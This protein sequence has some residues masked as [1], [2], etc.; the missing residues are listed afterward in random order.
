MTRTTLAKKERWLARRKAELGI[1]GRSYVA[2]NS[3]T[4][5]TRSKR[6][7]LQTIEQQARSNGQTPR[8]QALID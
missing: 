6:R 8:F 1:E 7:L 5:R 4:R 2:V 3:G